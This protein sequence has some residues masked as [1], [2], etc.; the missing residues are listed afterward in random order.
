MTPFL[1]ARGCCAP[2]TPPLHAAVWDRC[3][4]MGGAEGGGGQV[5]LRCWI[6]FLKYL[7]LKMSNLALELRAGR[8]GGASAPLR[9]AAAPTSTSRPWCPHVPKAQ[10]PPV[11]LDGPGRGGG[12]VLDTPRLGVIGGIDQLR[13]AAFKASIGG[14]FPLIEAFVITSFGG[15]QLGAAPHGTAA[16]HVPRTRVSILPHTYAHVCMM[17]THPCAHTSYPH[18]HVSL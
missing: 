14:A 9:W 8:Q 12:G 13:A 10:E 18:A 16:M 17:H 5:V 11:G 3:R 2:H 4:W 6:D 1:A 15:V 7:D